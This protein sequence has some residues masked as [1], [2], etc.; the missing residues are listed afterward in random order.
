MSMESNELPAFTTAEDCRAWLAGAPVLDAA[1][2]QVRL[3]TQINRLNVTA[4]P[5]ADR[6]DI[7]ELLRSPIHDTQEESARRFV[8]KPLPLAAPEQAAFESCRALWHGLATGYMRCAEACFSNEDNMRPK[9]A[10]V[11]QRALAALVAR[12]FA[13]HRAGGAPGG[14]HWRV[15]H[16]L[17][18]AA[19]Q[20]DVVAQEVMDT[21]RLGK[22]PGTPTAAY[23]E[24]LLLGAAN[25]HEHTPRQTTWIG[26]WARRWS[27]KVRI[28]TSPPTLSTQAI[29]LCVDL[30]SD[31]PAGYRPLGTPEARWLDT[32]ELRKSLKTRLVM[33]EKGEPPAKLH[34]GEDCAQPAC[35]QVLKAVYQRW[36]KGAAV[37]GFERRPTSGRCRFVAG[38]DAIHYYLSDRKP[39]KHAAPSDLSRMRREQE[40]IATFGHIATHHDEHFSQQHGYAVEQWQMLENWYMVDTAVAGMRLARPLSQA[41][42]RLANGQL[43]AVCPADG[44]T[45]L[46]GSVRWALVDEAFQL[47]VHLFAGHP[48]PVALRGTG[49]AAAREQYRQAF[50]LPAVAA[51]GQEA[52]VVMPV[53]TFK[54]GRTVEVF[55]GQARSL[56]LTRLVER[57]ADFERAA[58]EPV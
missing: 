52:S 15:L 22:T 8:G 24:G 56:R 11:L 50:L 9:A 27:A 42:V 10:L 58:Y 31:Q 35:E 21:P 14:E 44:E 12:Q 53:G 16:Q 57:G 40:E 2:V 51:I 1:Q 17:Y 4:I 30:A 20:L 25:L 26:R 18:A 6:L 43:V 28:L 48:E 5:A 37:R 39:F 36:C 47:G 32:M 45:F 41:G 3:L 33:L 7:L 55:T 13:I 34:L 46:V 23:V 54:L 38:I 29:P 49:P 19:E